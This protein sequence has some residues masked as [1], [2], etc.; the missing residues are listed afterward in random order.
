M[1]FMKRHLAISL[2][3]LS[4]LLV[5]H[6][7]ILA[8]KRPAPARLT[9]VGT[10]D[11]TATPAPPVH[12]TPA[13]QRRQD[14]FMK[15]WTLL[16]QTYFDK[17]FN[18]LDWSKIRAEYQPRI[19][20]AAT[21]ADAH[22]IL[23][24]MILLL[25]RS[26]F[27][28]VSPEFL[29]T[30]KEARSASRSKERAAAS[31]DE[32]PSSLDDPDDMM[33]PE[34]GLFVDPAA[35]FGIGVDVRYIDKHFMVTSVAPKSSALLAGIKPGF[36]IEKING[37][38]L[39][40]FVTR[41]IITYPNSR[42][43]RQVLP[44]AVV[45]WFLNSKYKT[46]V[47]LTCLDEKD[48]SREFTIPRLALAGKVV[49][50]G[51]KFPPEYLEYTSSS[52]GDVG[53]IKFNVFALPVLEKF[54][55]SLTEFSGKKG[56]IIDLRGNSGGL[57]ATLYALTGMLTDRS[58]SLG[59]SIYRRGSEEMRIE[60]KAKHFP[61]KVVLIVDDQTM[62]AGEMFSAGLQENARAIVVGEKTPGVALPASTTVLATGALF[63]YP[64]ANFKTS[65]GRTL[66]GTGVTP[67]ITVA[68][69]RRSLLEGR[70]PQLDQ[71]LEVI[72]NATAP[73]KKEAV[74]AAIPFDEEP[75]PPPPPAKAPDRA[76]TAIKAQ[77]AWSK[78][79]T[80]KDPKAVAVMTD[81]AAAVGGLDGF[82]RFKSYEAIGRGTV[83]IVGSESEIDLHI[84]REKPDK[85]TMLM[86]AE[87]IGQIRQ[88]YSP[89]GSFLQTEYGMEIPLGAKTDLTKV[90][91]FDGVK[92]ALDP[93]AFKWLAYDG[94]FEDEGRKLHVIEA[95]NA[96]GVTMAMTF[97]VKTK[98]LFRISF[99]G[100][101]YTLGDFRKVDSLTLPFSIKLDGVIDVQL[102]SVKLNPTIPPETFERK[103]NCFD[104]PM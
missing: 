67:D 7:G 61:G 72:K 58:I 55:G 68:R 56:I 80:S 17:T 104:K 23:Q 102:D 24:E 21:D 10:V 97:D 14:A 73:P 86:E 25:D 81:F 79:P 59:T 29:D 101:M 66:E 99:P 91:L 95:R 88:V 1:L 5:G 15:V 52:M 47:T 51:N 70:D 32:H 49:S 96:A 50:F 60:S 89:K 43:I 20:A 103:L 19:T 71:A 85:Y 40:D 41:T 11:V 76:L 94:I 48:Q 42:E 83:G 16:D 36:I 63:E 18:G 3:L 6:A 28:I 30:V 4:L 69:D 45:N 84:Y 9:V 92:D 53:Y 27:A 44:L 22:K 37:L 98:M 57:L 87:S 2:L 39:E 82:D 35:R 93:A 75:V 38:A 34:K 77:P 100:Y 12:L 31:H 65:K 46:P 54:C 33:D 78:Q 62:S 64:V 74:K 90:D 13:Q 8:Q 26:H